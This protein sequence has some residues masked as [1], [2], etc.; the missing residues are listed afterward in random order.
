[1][2][3]WEIFQSTFTPTFSS[4]PKAPYRSYSAST[5]WNAFKIQVICSNKL[6]L[7]RGYSDIQYSEKGVGVGLRE[8]FVVMMGRHIHLRTCARADQFSVTL[9]TEHVWLP[10][11]NPFCHIRW[12][13]SCARQYLFKKYLKNWYRLFRSHKLK[14]IIFGNFDWNC[15]MCVVDPPCPTSTYTRVL[16]LGVNL[17]TAFRSHML[18]EWL[19]HSDVLYDKHRSLSSEGLHG[20]DIHKILVH[21]CNRLLTGL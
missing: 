11:T 16:K 20:I 3:L 18:L 2:A 1:V 13:C 9:G 10:I 12:T 8:N 4:I 7:L 6:N 5:M 21:L 14:W 15:T 19:Q 17:V